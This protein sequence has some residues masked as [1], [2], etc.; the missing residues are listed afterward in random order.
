MA[1]Q[2]PIISEFDGKGIKKAVA[3]FKQLEG[4]G[5][6]TGFLLKKAMLPATAAIGALGAG[7]L[8]AVDAA[9]DLAEAQSKVNV[10]FGDGAADII[11]YS[12]TAA[13]AI[14]QSQQSVLDAAG[15][16]G[17]FGKA[18]GLSGKDLAKFSNNFTALASDIASFS[19]ATPEEVITALGA[20]LRGESEPLRRF[21]V[22]L[23]AE[24]IEMEAVNMGLVKFSKNA[25]AV[26]RATLAVERAQQRYTLAVSRFGP[27]SLQARTAMA[28]Y[29]AQQEKLSK[30]MAG[31]MDKL[32]QEQ[33]I[34]AA[35]S[36]I[37]KQ[38][39]DAQGDFERTSS[40]LANQ[41][42]I[43]TAEYKNLT[44]QLGA[45]LLPAFQQ[46][47]PYLTRFAEWA[48]KNPGVVKVIAGAVGVLA[49]SIMA[50]NIA[51]M[52][53]PVALIIAGSIALGVAIV[54]L[55]KKFEGFRT[56]VRVVFNGILSYFEFF[57]NGFIRIVNGM[58]R[59][60]NIVKPGKDIPTLGHISLGRLGDD[61]D[62]SSGAS[63]IRA[64][65]TG[66]IV[67][68]PTLALIGEAGPEAV[69]PLDRMKGMGG[70]V[71]INVN[72]G[73]PQVVVEALRKWYRQ[74][75]PLPVA[76]QYG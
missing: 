11:A 31:K 62:A 45:A 71:T 18:A 10:I 32:T 66:G 27:D 48:A 59:A 29:E 46:L 6:K 49:A 75:G 64:M 28:A 63:G 4:A 44:V 20:G 34:L 13:R 54:A 5:K 1:L 15:T 36:L 52:A 57:Y 42:R 30:A 2:I 43:L 69:I 16:F 58:I 55:Y 47:M 40:G 14:G 37:Y 8:K 21:G 65:A 50:L 74:N 73:D 51:M 19:N 38:T 76:V 68:G 24:A 9:S 17:T 56:V 33:K 53:N 35:T 67:T 3:E 22:L 61:Q 25:V 23:S 41:Q 39:A 12:K 26:K 60:L 72:G 7:A 70:A